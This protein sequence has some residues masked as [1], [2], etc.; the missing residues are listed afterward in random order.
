MIRTAATWLVAISLLLAGSVFTAEAQAAPSDVLSGTAWQLVSY[1][2][3]GAETPVLPGSSVTLTFQ[4]GGQVG[5]NAGCNS[6][7]G[8]Y[9]V[10]ADSIAFNTLVS[11]LMACA[12]R[13]VTQQEQTYLGALGTSGWFD[14]QANA[15]TIQYDGGELHFAPLGDPPQAQLP[16]FERRDSPVELLASY[17]DAISRQDYQRAY[18]Y[19]ENPPN[20]YQDFA[21]G[22]A[23]TTSVQVI[24][25]P[26]T[27]YEGAAGSTYVSIPTVLLAQ[28]S[29]GT[30]LTFAGCFV[31]RK[32]NLMPPD[33]P[34]PDVWH[35]YSANVEQ[36]P[37]DS[38]IPALLSQVCSQEG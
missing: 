14:L 1:G 33:I 34:E 11:T 4:T 37:N 35:L 25:E 10:A 16:P 21:N 20:A 31:T 6:Y 38:A 12:D 29:D 15:L 7:G 22:F 18:G 32:S 24:I 28:H 2:P 8:G 9:A 13:G 3:V 30:L 5:G 23:T 27:R 17:Y 26:P 19:W 36:V